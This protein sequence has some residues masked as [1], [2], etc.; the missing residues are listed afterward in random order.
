MTEKTVAAVKALVDKWDQPERKAE[1]VQDLYN[2]IVIATTEATSS[3][4]EI[5]ERKKVGYNF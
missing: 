5:K 4:K 2:L 1:L 3:I